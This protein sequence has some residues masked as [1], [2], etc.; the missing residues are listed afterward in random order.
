MKEKLQ[1]LEER[2]R[3][4]QA[5][6]TSERSRSSVPASSSVKRRDRV[7]VC[8]HMRASALGVQRLSACCRS[9]ALVCVTRGQ[10]V[11]RGSTTRAACVCERAYFDVS[12]IMPAR[13]RLFIHAARVQDAHTGRHTHTHANMHST[14][15]HAQQQRL[16][17]ILRSLVRTN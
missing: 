4:Q 2:K 14:S 16:V 5:V 1:C 17:I 10:G 12:V 6:L 15:T 8:C 9:S 11:S 3:R 13:G 7:G